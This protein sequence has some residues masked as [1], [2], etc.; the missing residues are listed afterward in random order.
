MRL[1]PGEYESPEVKLAEARICF[2]YAIEEVAP[3]ILAGL[4]D[5]VL[6]CY[7][8]GILSLAMAPK[9]LRNALN[10]WA[11]TFNL[12]CEWVLEQAFSTLFLWQGCPF[13]LESGDLEWG[14]INGGTYWNVAAKHE[15]SLVFEDPGW[16]PASETWS[17]AK[18]RIEKAFQLFLEGYRNYISKLA[19]E[20]GYSPKRE[21]RLRSSDDPLLHFKWLVHYQTQEWPY[22]RIAKE[23]LGD[24]DLINTV[25]DAVKQIA[26]WIEL[27]LRSRGP[28]RPRKI[29]D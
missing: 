9:N 27:P 3:E 19:Y 25:R 21:I 28:G 29:Y 11:N 4:R 15:R 20:R 5:K 24:R 17:E 14:I 18:K 13:M 7:E 6:P 16:D 22:S 10:V 26:S 8:P 12:N 2:F 23:Y 1:G